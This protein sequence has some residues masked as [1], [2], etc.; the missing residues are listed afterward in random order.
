MCRKLRAK[1]QVIEANLQKNPS[2]LKIVWRVNFGTGI[3]FGTDVA[4]R[5]GEGSEVLVFLRKKRGRKTV[6]IL[7]SEKPRWWQNSTDSSAVLFLVR[8]GPLG[9]CRRTTR[10]TSIQSAR[11]LL[12][13]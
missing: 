5:Y 2:V 9:T 8:K 10:T 6:R 7:N 1:F 3:K 12:H 11:Q 4:K 13:N